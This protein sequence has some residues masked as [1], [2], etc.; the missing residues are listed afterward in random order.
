MG[1][2]YIE[3][4][5]YDNGVYRLSSRQ[6]FSYT[7]SNKVKEKVLIELDGHTQVWDSLEMYVYEYD[8]QDRPTKLWRMDLDPVYDT[9]ALWE[10]SYNSAGQLVSIKYSAANINTGVWNTLQRT[11]F[12]Y[13]NGNLTEQ[14]VQWRP[15]GVW[16]DASKVQYWY[17]SSGQLI[18]KRDGTYNSTFG[19]TYPDQW[20][21]TYN[22]NNL[23]DTLL[24]EK[25][26]TSQS[27]WYENRLKYYGYTATNK[28]LY[29]LD[30]LKNHTDT[31]WTF[32]DSTELTY[33][34]D[35]MVT[36][37]MK[38][39]LQLDSNNWEPM[40][41]SDIYPDAPSNFTSVVVPEDV[42]T[43]FHDPMDGTQKV[44]SI[45]NSYYSSVGASYTQL[46]KVVFS[47]SENI[48]NTVSEIENTPLLIYPNPANDELFFDLAPTLNGINIE[49]YNATGSLVK[50]GQ[51]SAF[52]SMD[53]SQLTPGIYFYSI[54]LN[55]KPNSGSFIKN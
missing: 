54:T 12:T 10:R 49:I 32:Y 39:R 4:Y 24:Q 47:Y 23:L 5:P 46:G 29:E 20:F 33:N 34:S 19:W 38:W 36:R 37:Y 3:Q 14:L 9:I 30:A 17:N 13:S 28:F 48:V 53:I 31:A 27:V 40:N 7:N 8:S 26:Y 1:L 22:N 50:S 6:Y 41:R 35:E 15:N 21:Y 16:E 51:I 43:Y 55:G 44:D 11:V 18:Q 42:F 2:D 52:Q 45:Y 25:W